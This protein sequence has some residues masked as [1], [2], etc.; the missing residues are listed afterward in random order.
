MKRLFYG[1]VMS[2]LISGIPAFAEDRARPFTPEELLG[3]STLVFQGTVLQVEADG[4]D[5]VAF[6]VKAGIASVVKGKSDKTELSFK[7]KSGKFVIFQEEFNRPEIG[8]KG[9]FYLQDMGGILV[10]IG[11]LKDAVYLSREIIARE[12]TRLANTVQSKKAFMAMARMT[13]TRASM[14]MHSIG[15][16]E[17]TI[18]VYDLILKQDRADLL[19]MN[20][21]AIVCGDLERHYADQVEVARSPEK[22]GKEDLEQMRK[23]EYLLLGELQALEENRGQEL[24]RRAQVAPTSP[25]PEGQGR[26]ETE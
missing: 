2:L 14:C 7:H 9:T 20:A 6:P 5:K 12:T 16:M 10:L 26:R 21:L 1:L 24:K 4:A 13:G 11:Y 25:M 3:Q 8:Q 15:R 18:V 22:T 19:V 17:A 23:R